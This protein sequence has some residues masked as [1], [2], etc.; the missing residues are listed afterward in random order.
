[1]IVT[2]IRKGKEVSKL[3]SWNKWRKKTER[4]QLSPGKTAVTADSGR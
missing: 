3:L 2:L 1:L 4:N